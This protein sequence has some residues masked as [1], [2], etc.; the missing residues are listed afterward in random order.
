MVECEYKTEVQERFFRRHGVISYTDFSLFT[1]QKERSEMQW[2]L[3]NF[4]ALDKI[5][6]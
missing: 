5:S 3:K 1:S 4:V 2:H 6:N